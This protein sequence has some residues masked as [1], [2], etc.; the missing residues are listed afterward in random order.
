MQVVKILL[1]RLWIVSYMND[2]TTNMSPKEKVKELLFKFYDE[3]DIDRSK[4]KQCALIC[5]VEIQKE[6]Y[7]DKIRLGRKYNN[8]EYWQKVK[9]EIEKL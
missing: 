6:S 8:Y 4:T 5:I 3:A 1:F 9:E 7:T 2:K